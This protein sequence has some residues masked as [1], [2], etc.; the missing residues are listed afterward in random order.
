MSHKLINIEAARQK[1]LAEVNVNNFS[2]EVSLQK[3]LMRINYK[4]IVSD[5]D[6]PS[7][8]NSAVDGYGISSQTFD[9]QKI[10]FRVTGVAKAGHPFKGIIGF[11]EAIEI[12]TGAI[13]PEGVDTVIM[14]EKCKRVGNEVLVKGEVKKLQN[15]RPIGENLCKGE[16][17]VKKEN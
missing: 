12:Y 16:T 2:T 11:G 10:K 8:T 9:N 7:T 14:H 4:S 6:L 17:I 5:I 13:V 15:I 1:L 3:A